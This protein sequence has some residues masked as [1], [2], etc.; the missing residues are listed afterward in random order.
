MD[1]LE[2]EFI[3]LLGIKRDNSSLI[4]E[5]KE[6][7]NNHIGSLHA[8]ALYTL[9]EAQSGLFLQDS[10]KE[11]SADAVPL[12]RCSKTTYK[13]S[14]TSVVKAF[15]SA[16]KNDLEKFKDNFLK[17]GRATISIKVELLDSKKRIVMLGEFKW[18]VQRVNK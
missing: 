4:L 8:G 6:K 14:A 3:K 1:I 18:F 7:L 10:F 17:K 5:P 15:A 9:A 2:I 11:F 16:N 13:N 12:L